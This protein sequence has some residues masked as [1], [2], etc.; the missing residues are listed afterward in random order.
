[1]RYIEKHSKLE[2]LAIG[3]EIIENVRTGKKNI[4]RTHDDYLDAISSCALAI[5]LYN[6]GYKATLS[7]AA[8]DDLKVGVPILALN[9]P[10][11]VSTSN[12]L[13]DKIV[14]VREDLFQVS[15]YLDDLQY[16]QSHKL[17]S[18]SLILKSKYSVEAIAKIVDK[19][20]L[21]D[22]K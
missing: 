9:R 7:A 15:E 20:F 13:G 3:G 2:F 19:I 17:E 10:F 18:N 12:H 21:G 4:L 8:L 14:A 11:F 22:K 16:S 1:M 5:F 6:D